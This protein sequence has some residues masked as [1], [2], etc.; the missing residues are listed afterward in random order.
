MCKMGDERHLPDKLWLSKRW[1]HVIAV[2]KLVAFAATCIISS[3]FLRLRLQIKR[4]YRSWTEK[5]QLQLAQLNI[6]SINLPSRT[7]PWRLLVCLPVKLASFIRFY[8]F[9][10]HLVE[11]QLTRIS[12]SFYF[13][14]LFYS[15]C[16]LWEDSLDIEMEP[17]LLSHLSSSS[18]S[19]VNF[20]SCFLRHSPFF[21][22]TDVCVLAMF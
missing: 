14:L 1:T 9:D 3:V 4:G 16:I 10:R 5:V 21:F 17:E 22:P 6:I 13:I 12:F 19:A 2:F 8:H 7:L 18:S 20:C 15:F 11:T